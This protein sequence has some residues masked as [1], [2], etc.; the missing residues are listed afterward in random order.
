MPVRLVSRIWLQSLFGH[1]D[2][3]HA[4]GRAG[5]GDD[6]VDLLKR[7]QARVA[8]RA[9]RRE[10]ADVGRMTQRPPAARLD[11]SRH[12]VDD[13]APP[14]GHD[15]VGAG[16]GQPQGERVPDAGRAANDHRRPSREIEEA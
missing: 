10:V 8:Q 16:V 6:D 1:L 13:V 14:A 2:R 9:Q 5:G 11:F 4:L 15:D 12:A 3:R 7:G